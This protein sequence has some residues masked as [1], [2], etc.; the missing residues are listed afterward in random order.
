MRAFLFR[1]LEIDGINYYQ[2]YDEKEDFENSP[3]FSSFSDYDHRLEND[4][5]Y[6][7]SNTELEDPISLNIY[8]DGDDGLKAVNDAK[9]FDRIFDVFKE[10]FNIDIH[11]YKSVDEIVNEVDKTVLFQKP[12][13]RELV[14]QIYLNQTIMASDL[15]VELKL[16]Q[17]NNILFHGVFGSGKKSIIEILEKNLN[18]PYA[19]IT[20]TGELKNDLAH[21]MDQ[22]IEHSKNDAEASTGIV[23]IRDNFLELIDMFEDKAYSIPSFFTSQEVIIY[24]KHKID[25]RT[26]TF[27]V[28]FDEKKNLYDHDDIKEIKNMTD[29][30][31]DVETEHLFDMSKY[32]ILLSENGRLNHYAR[33]LNQYGKKLVLDEK[34]LRR[35]IRTCSSIDPGMNLLNSVIDTIIKTSLLDGVRDVHIDQ[36]CADLFIPVIASYSNKDS[37]PAPT[38]RKEEAIFNDELKGVYELVTKN[39]VGQDKQVKTVLYTILENRR[40]A[41]K[42][43]LVDPK[44]YIKNILI[45][46]ESGSGKTMIVETISKALKI[47]AFI[48]DSTKYTEEGYVG[49]SVSEMLVNLYHA[50]GDNLEEAEKGIL[51][52]DELD[53]KVN[54]ENNSSDI[55]RGAVLDGMLKIIEG[56]VIPI[57]VGNRIQ[58]QIVM[59]DTSRLTVICSGA[60]EGIEKYRDKRLG[61]EK[62][63]G[64]GT[65]QEEEVNNDTIGTDENKII[66]ADYVSYGMNKQ[67]MARLPLMVELN[68]NTV[69]SLVNIMKLSI[70][71]ALKVEKYILEDR[72][73]EIEYT[74][75][76]YTELA[77]E[78]LALEIGARGISKALERVLSSI[79][80]E[81][82]DARDVSKIVFD[83]EVVNNP[84]KIILI[85]REKDKQKVIK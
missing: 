46:G 48:A 15:P 25:F 53:K 55:S 85:P 52:I 71:S 29:C 33:F 47:P 14:N 21:I 81:D 68:K 31:C 56:A 44:K 8:T 76:F 72:G 67:F 65:H 16:K 20:I 58:E 63:L 43:E 6:V 69:E 59:F 13:V 34:S 18:I 9:E 84:E 41:N 35:I 73:I 82:I 3:E 23:F 77:K 11:E 64:F 49:G 17:K 22:L 32:K 42:K 79:H 74:E 24:G 39:V 51:F 50:A 7:D 54:S 27:V 78:A 30:E 28:L 80:I 40:M 70:S 5:F 75:S 60:F 57:N 36:K 1:K 4:Y 2:L 37:K 38:R 66:D 61:K 26:L 62:R 45:R 19:D 12:T 83:G 10:K